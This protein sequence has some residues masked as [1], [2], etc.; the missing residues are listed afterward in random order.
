MLLSK[1]KYGAV[2]KRLLIAVVGVSTTI[3]ILTTSVQLGLDY[4]EDMRRMNGVFQQIKASSVPSIM[5]SVW[6]F[7]EPQIK[8]Q[9]DAFVQIPEVVY[10]EI[11]QDDEVVWKAGKIEADRTLKEEE[12]ELIAKPLNSSP[13][14]LGKLKVVA[15]MSQIYS[16]LIDKFAVILVSNGIK[17]AIVAVVI[18]LV[19][20]NLV[21]RHLIR[22][23]EYLKS[24]EPGDAT[25]K[26]TLLRGPS[27]ENDE[28]DILVNAIN[29]NYQHYASN[30][31]YSS[32]SDNEGV[33]YKKVGEES[34]NEDS[35]AAN[36]TLQQQKQD[37]LVETEKMAAL[38]GLLEGITQDIEH[39]LSTS[40]SATKALQNQLLEAEHQCDEESVNKNVILALLHNCQN[41]IKT[42]TSNLNSVHRMTSNIRRFASDREKAVF[43]N[44]KLK[45]EVE[46]VVDTVLSQHPT[47]SINTII[48]I[49]EAIL[50][51]TYPAAIHQLLINLVSNALQHGFGEG[52]VGVLKVGAE[53]KGDTVVLTVA[54]DGKGMDPETLAHI[55]DPFFTTKVNKGGTGLGMY[56]V[57]NIVTQKLQGTIICESQP[58][59]GA[60]FIISLPS[61]E[62]TNVVDLGAR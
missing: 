51:S 25:K 20:W 11:R 41:H 38:G 22:M 4:W 43:K 59:K 48:N 52:A 60:K 47:K 50:L 45:E 57:Y 19:F 10:A 24:T 12:F 58:D 54:D 44:V 3:A 8:I 28:L 18:L 49:D 34:A 36:V 39:P 53:E 9:L 27:K 31:H 21:T 40:K 5:R 13:I 30:K 32:I 6:L 29:D 62:L 46:E 61:L 1:Q 55:F 42:L 35:N 7:D 26:L 14:D 2:A 16:R 17:T 56:I 37:V 23:S 15:D 33:L